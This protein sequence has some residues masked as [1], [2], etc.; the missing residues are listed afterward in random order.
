MNCVV[1]IILIIVES[2]C[3][4]VVGH[5]SVRYVVSAVERAFNALY[6]SARR[7]STSHALFNITSTWRQTSTL[8]LSLY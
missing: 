6:P 7:R 2:C 4:R 5:W 3:R 1:I 8:R